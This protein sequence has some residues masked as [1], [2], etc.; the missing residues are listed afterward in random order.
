MTTFKGIVKDNMVML[1]EGIHLPDGAE[2]EVRLVERTL[3]PEEAFAQLLANPITHYVGM[4]EILEK[5][6]RER[7]GR[8]EPRP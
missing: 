2:V 8:F 5:E 6:K 3:S 7:E 1:E 4:D